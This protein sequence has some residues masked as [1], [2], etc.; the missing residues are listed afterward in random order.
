MIHDF[1]C[2]VGCGILGW[3]FLIGFIITALFGIKVGKY[4]FLIIPWYF[5]LFLVGS[6][7]FLIICA[8]LMTRSG[9]K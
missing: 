2:S 6:I 1:K 7:T 3:I 5:W 4:K 8:I 9:Y